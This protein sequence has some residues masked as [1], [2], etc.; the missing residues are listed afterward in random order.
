MI[1]SLQGIISKLEPKSLI[2]DVHGLGYRVG[3]LGAL[4]ADVTIGQEMIL[5]IHHHVTDSAETLYGFKTQE[6]LNFFELLLTVPSVGPRTALNILDIAPPATLAQAVIEDDIKLL[7]KV[8]GIGRK[9]AN[10]IIIEL[11]GKIDETLISGAPSNVQ[12]ETVSALV[13][14]GF[15]REQARA[16]IKELPKNV[17]TV[18][19]A[20]KAALKENK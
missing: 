8:S 10:R 4:L 13:S 11:K 2:I 17:T 19:E 7:T 16:L 9:T 12:T 6:D 3:A 1:A 14:L 15:T 5:L 18:Q 20:V